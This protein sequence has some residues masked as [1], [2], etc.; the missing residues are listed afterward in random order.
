M[1]VTCTQKCHIAHFKVL[2]IVEHSQDSV[3]LREQ[4]MQSDF[5]VDAPSHFLHAA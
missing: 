3:P 4:S 5:N 1:K 2:H